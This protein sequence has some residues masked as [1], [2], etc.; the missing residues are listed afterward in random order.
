MQIRL[1]FYL[2]LVD[3]FCT[4]NRNQTEL[5]EVWFGTVQEY[6]SS[7]NAQKQEKH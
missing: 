3:R 4:S 5:T 2:F 1:E 7:E 6:Q